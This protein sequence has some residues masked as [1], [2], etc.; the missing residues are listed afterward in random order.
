MRAVDHHQSMYARMYTKYTEELIM[1]KM[2]RHVLSQLD[3]L[4]LG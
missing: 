1:T 4:Q 2:E 3:I